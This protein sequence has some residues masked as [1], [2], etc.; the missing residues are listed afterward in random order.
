MDPKAGARYKAK[1]IKAMSHP[2][3][4]LVVDELSKGKRCVCKLTEMIGDD[5]STVSK[6]LSVLKNAGLVSDEKRGTQVFYSLRC[7]CILDFFSCVESAL[8][9]N[10]KEQAALAK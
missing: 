6:H 3:R 7:R 4:L 1:I 10:I 8:R 5:I 2:T 9:I